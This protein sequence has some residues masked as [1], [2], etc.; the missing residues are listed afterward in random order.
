MSRVPCTMLPW[1]CT[2]PQPAANSPC[3]SPG[4]W[5]IG[6]SIVVTPTTPIVFGGNTTVAGNLTIPTGATVRVFVGAVVTVE[7]CV[8]ID[9]DLVV[10]T[11][12]RTIANGTEVDLINYN[13]TACNTNARFSNVSVAGV[14]AEK[15]RTVSAQDSVSSRGLSVIFNVVDVPNCNGSPQSALI[16]PGDNTV[17]IIAGSVGGGIALILIVGLVLLYKF[18]FRIIPSYRMNSQMRRVSRSSYSAEKE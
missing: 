7:G 5:L 4:R 17:A 6:G 16:Q 1:N 18:R 9:G 2:G 12:G 8:T 11:S 10:D 13:S 3:V 14:I 15:C